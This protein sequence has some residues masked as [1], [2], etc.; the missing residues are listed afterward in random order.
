VRVLIS[1]DREWSKRG[2]MET[3]FLGLYT[4]V[5]KQLIII[6]G[7]ARGADRMARDI[8]EIYLQPENILRFP[9]D[10]TKYGKGAGPIR[11]KQML[12]EGEPDLVLCFH[13]DIQSS[14]GTKNM[15]EQAEKAGVPVYVISRYSST[16]KST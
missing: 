15:A 4:Q 1:G 16:S 10:W 12:V 11:N 2:I 5:G 14:K 8:A 3:I 7:E 6:E 13:D 9:A